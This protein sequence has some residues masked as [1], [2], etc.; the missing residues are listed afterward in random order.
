MKIKVIETGTKRALMNTQIQLQ[1]K[2]KDSGF[3]SLTTGPDG[4]LT[5][6]EKYKGQQLTVAGGQAQ[7]ITAAEGATLL[8]PA[9][10]K[11]TETQN[12]K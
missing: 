2:G 12:H 10:Q 9:K 8:V 6:D 11:S 5:L 3:L 7:W 4:M 1:I